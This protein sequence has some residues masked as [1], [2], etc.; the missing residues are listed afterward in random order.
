MKVRAIRMGYYNLKRR[1]EGE[2]FEFD[3]KQQVTTADGLKR[4]VKLG[5]WMEPLEDEPR[6]STRRKAEPERGSV[7]D[8]DVL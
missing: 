6:P 8:Q 2:V 7:S 1:R 5:S 3:E 4:T